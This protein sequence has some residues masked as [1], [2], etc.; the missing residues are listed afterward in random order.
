MSTQNKTKA[1]KI[2][3]KQNTKNGLVSEKFASLCKQKS[4]EEEA[5]CSVRYVPP[6]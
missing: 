4:T 3:G 5:V 2:K 6:A 1:C